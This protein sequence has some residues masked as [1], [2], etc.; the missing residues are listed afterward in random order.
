MRGKRLSRGNGP[1]SSVHWDER[2]VTVIK[3]SDKVHLS[4][5]E[6]KRLRDALEELFPRCQDQGT[7]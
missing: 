3:G 7:A 4:M 2:G 6:G 5:N 1:L